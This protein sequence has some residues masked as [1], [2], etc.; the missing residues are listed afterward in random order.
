MIL[1]PPNSNSSQ[2][3]YYTLRVAARLKGPKRFK[4]IL[5]QQPEFSCG[6]AM[7]LDHKDNDHLVEYTFYSGPYGIH[8]GSL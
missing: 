8:N 1:F 4:F 6:S 5:V 3:G 7:I 2:T